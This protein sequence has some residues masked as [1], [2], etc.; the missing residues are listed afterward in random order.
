M[1]VFINNI[2]GSLLFVLF[3]RIESITF[4]SCYEC[5]LL[6]MLFHPVKS[7]NPLQ[8]KNHHKDMNMFAQ[9]VYNFH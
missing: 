7:I 5:L 3:Y 6:E 1:I 9:D 2:T 4:R 8:A